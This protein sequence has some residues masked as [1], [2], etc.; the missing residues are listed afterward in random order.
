M[1]DTAAGVSSA[2]ERHGV[3]VLDLVGPESSAPSVSLPRMGPVSR[4]RRSQTGRTAR[5]LG[6]TS[7]TDGAQSEWPPQIHPVHPAAAMPNRDGTLDLTRDLPQTQE[8]QLL[9]QPTAAPPA[10]G[11][12]LPSALLGDGG[13]FGAEHG[14]LALDPIFEMRPLHPSAWDNSRGASLQ[15]PGDS[16]ALPGSNAT[17]PDTSRYDRVTSGPSNTSRGGGG[18]GRVAAAGNVEAQGAG[19]NPHDNGRM[20][21][22]DRG[23]PSTRKRAREAGTAQAESSRPDFP[24]EPGSSNNAAPEFI[25]LASPNLAG[26]TGNVSPPVLSLDVN[27]PSNDSGVNP[28]GATAPDRMAELI[29]LS[30]DLANRHRRRRLDRNGRHEAGQPGPQHRRARYNSIDWLT[31]PV[32]HLRANASNRPA[33]SSRERPSRA[34]WGEAMPTYQI[35]PFLRMGSGGRIVG[36]GPS[37]AEGRPSGSAHRLSFDRPGFLAGFPGVFPSPESLALAATLAEAENL[38]LFGDSS[39]LSESRMSDASRS[40]ALSMRL[41]LTDRDFTE[42]DYEMLLRLDD[43]IGQQGLKKEKIEALPTQRASTSDCSEQC[44]V[45][46]EN[47]TKGQVMRVLPCGHSFHRQC[48]DKW[49]ERSTTCPICKHDAGRRK[50][51]EED[52]KQRQEKGKAVITLTDDPDSSSD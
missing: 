34:H 20:G 23:A 17:C 9:G 21:G 18:G 47:Y 6:P 45:C 30:R 24:G 3:T 26:A 11:I 50:E 38:A 41:A 46:L 32:F 13:F 4:R 37:S 16:T 31:S 33:E 15:R 25:D 40:A 7:G 19:I 48:I 22:A 44:V 1:I 39:L 14:H 27:P 8:P 10:S 52:A 5:F 29:R 12:P 49:L 43:G 35:L 42:D 2:R 28:T 36:S 51:T